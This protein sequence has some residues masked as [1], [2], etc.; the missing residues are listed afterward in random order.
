[1]AFSNIFSVLKWSGTYFSYYGLA[2]TAPSHA[3]WALGWPGVINCTRCIALLI[4]LRFL[5]RSDTW[6]TNHGTF[7]IASLQISWVLRLS[8]TSHSSHGSMWTASLH[9]S[10]VIRDKCLMYTNHFHRTCFLNKSIIF[11]FIQLG[12][13]GVKLYNTWFTFITLI[14]IAKIWIVYC[15]Y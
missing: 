8:R 5:K 9:I 11:Y 12:Q 10:W 14:F 2:S 7:S 3:L 6:N 1:M 13:A 15:M 4:I